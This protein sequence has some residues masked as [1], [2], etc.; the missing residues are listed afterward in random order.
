MARKGTGQTEDRRMAL[1]GTAA[2]SGVSC[3]G[4]HVCLP[5]L[6]SEASAGLSPSYFPV[7]PV[8]VSFPLLSKSSQ[9]L[10][11]SLCF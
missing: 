9:C 8:T 2:S 1:Q 4:D 6:P 3:S 5:L 7:K 10:Y 11:A